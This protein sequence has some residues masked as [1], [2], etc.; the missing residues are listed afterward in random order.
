[1]QQFG[2][3]QPCAGMAGRGTQEQFSSR[4]GA[5]EPSMDA[6]V[7]MEMQLPPLGGSTSTAEQAAVAGLGQPGLV[8]PSRG[9]KGDKRVRAEDAEYCPD[10]EDD[11]SG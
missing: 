3:G 5:A 10:V 2:A 9:A 8:L 1:M 11:D 6:N 7:G 4:F